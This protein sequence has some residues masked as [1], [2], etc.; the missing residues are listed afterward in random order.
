VDVMA[1]N[2]NEYEVKVNAYTGKVIAIIPG[3]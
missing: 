3:G 2:G 1:T